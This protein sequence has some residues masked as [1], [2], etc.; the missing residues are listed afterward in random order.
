MK[1]KGKKV[2]KYL[3]S[4]LDLIRSGFV[5][6][7]PLGWGFSMLPNDTFLQKTKKTK[8]NKIKIKK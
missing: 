8:K 2:L 3:Y 1:I 7:D 4:T 6:S 5:T